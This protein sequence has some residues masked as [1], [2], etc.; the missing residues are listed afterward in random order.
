MVITIWQ[1]SIVE[2]D[3]TTN[4]APCQLSH[5][6]VY[7]LVG[8]EQCARKRLMNDLD[9]VTIRKQESWFS[10][11]RSLIQWKR[12]RAYLGTFHIFMMAR[13]R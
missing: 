7:W 3:G 1:K 2:G 4:Q 9:A 11:E 10:S 5:R 8:L 6:R 13:G 12:T